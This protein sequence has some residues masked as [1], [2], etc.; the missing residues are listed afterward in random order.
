MQACGRIKDPSTGHFNVLVVGGDRD[1]SNPSP[2]VPTWT[3]DPLTG[4]VKNVTTFPSATYSSLRM[5][6]FSDYEVLV[7]NPQDGLLQSFTLEDGWQQVANLP[8]FKSTAV[9]PMI[10]PKGLFKCQ[11]I[12]SSGS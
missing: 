6:E 9:V 10:V 5:V 1:K 2:V 3:W 12:Y 8:N 4:V 11:S 7:L